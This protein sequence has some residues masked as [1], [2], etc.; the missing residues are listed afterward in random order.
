MREEKE[1]REGRERGREKKK[2]ERGERD[3]ERYI[4]YPLGC[5]PNICKNRLGQAEARS[6]ELKSSLPHWERLRY[7]N[8]YLMSLRCGLVDNWILSGGAGM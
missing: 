2:G 6:Q 3:R 4:F 7:L 5:S 8:C 1:R